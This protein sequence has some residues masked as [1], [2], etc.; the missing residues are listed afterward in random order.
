MNKK[1][2]LVSPHVDEEFARRI[3]DNILVPNKERK[4]LYVPSNFLTSE[5]YYH[6][7]TTMADG[8]ID[9]RGKTLANWFLEKE[10]VDWL[11]QK[12][13]QLYLKND[14]KY[15][16]KSGVPLDWSFFRSKVPEWI[17][18]YAK[19]ENVYKFVEDP[20]SIHT[21]DHNLLYKYYIEALSKINIEFFKKYYYFVKKVNDYE[22]PGM[23]GVPDFNPYKA[24]MTVGSKNEFENDIARVSYQDMVY[25]PEKWDQIDVWSDQDT[26]RWNKNFRYNNEIPCWQSPGA[27][28]WYDRSNDGLRDGNPDRASLDNQIHGYN[29]QDVKKYTSFAYNKKNNM[30]G[31]YT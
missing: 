19:D 25:F 3:L 28:R 11:T 24:R 29:M 30:T 26:V 14:Y 17:R 8:I 5:R 22:L 10:N 4:T 18:E 23:T 1:A 12:L 15:Q 9:I 2:N 16:V 31:S 21:S 6:A 20:I 7:R 13:F 27:K